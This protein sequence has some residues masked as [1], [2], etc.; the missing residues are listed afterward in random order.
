MS[1]YWGGWCP[2]LVDEEIAVAALVAFADF[3]GDFEERTPRE[4]IVEVE[5]VVFTQL[6]F[7]AL[8]DVGDALAV[9]SLLRGSTLGSTMWFLAQE[10]RPRTVRG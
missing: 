3:G 9:G 2:V 7:V 8:I 5:G 1:S 10:M 6:G 4:E